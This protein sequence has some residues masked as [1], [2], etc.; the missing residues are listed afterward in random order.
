VIGPAGVGVA[1]GNV[2]EVIDDAGVCISVSVM[3]KVVL[4]KLKHPTLVP[5]SMCLQLADQL[6]R[7][8]SG[9]AKNVQVKI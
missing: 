5:T 2:V 8:P 9:I 6:V 1:V 7:Y 3:P 4:D